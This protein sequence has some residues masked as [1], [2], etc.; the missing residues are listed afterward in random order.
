M[1]LNMCM[2]VELLYVLLVVGIALTFMRLVEL[3]AAQH[4]HASGA[5]LPPP[6]PPKVKASVAEFMD[7]LWESWSQ[8]GMGLKG[9][10]SHTPL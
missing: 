10:M 9:G 2:L 8:L 1:L 6:P 3:G 7:P 5:S 4:V